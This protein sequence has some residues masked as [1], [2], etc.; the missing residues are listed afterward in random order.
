MHYP[1]VSARLPQ[2]GTA[3]SAGKQSG[4]VWE[5]NKRTYFVICQ[6]FL[7]LPRFGLAAESRKVPLINELIQLIFTALFTEQH[8]LCRV[9]YI[10]YKLDRV[11]LVDPPKTSLDTWHVTGRGR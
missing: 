3:L 5:D 6:V 4:K 10:L 2:I 8:W 7:A 11:G 1:S 9:C